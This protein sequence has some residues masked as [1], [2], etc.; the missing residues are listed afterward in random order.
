VAGSRG[1]NYLAVFRRD[2]MKKV[3]G[4]V[5]PFRRDVYGKFPP[6]SVRLARAPISEFTTAKS[7]AARHRRGWRVALAEGHRM[8]ALYIKSY[9]GPEVMQIGE[10]P[11]PRPRRREVVVAIK[12]SSINPVELEGPRRRVEVLHRP[13]LF[14]R[15]LAPTS[16][17]VDRTGRRGVTDLSAGDRVYGVTPLMLRK[18]GP[19]LSGW[20]WLQTV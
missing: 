6:L 14:R 13:H 3:Y 16:P 11:D 10:L 1:Y 5:L 7:W 9:G 4:K 2:T 20:L 18:P 8:R 19:R 15:P 17:A 12:A